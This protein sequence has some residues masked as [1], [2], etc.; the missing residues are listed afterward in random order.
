MVRNCGAKMAIKEQRNKK[1]IL[2]GDFV[3]HSQN[4]NHDM[5]L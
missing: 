5:N 4:K 1:K 2:A 3:N